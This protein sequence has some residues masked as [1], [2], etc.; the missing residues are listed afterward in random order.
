MPQCRY[1]PSGSPSRRRRFA[2]PVPR[3]KTTD[4]GVIHLGLDVS[5]DTIAVAILRPEELDAD[6]EKFVND[7]ASI[8]RLVDRFDDPRRLRA[9]FEAGPTGFE[10][11]RLLESLRVCTDVIAPSLIPRRPGDRVKTDKRDCRR[12]ARL[13]RAGELTAVRVPTRAEEGVRDLCRARHVAVTERRRARQRLSA[14]LLRHNEAWRE[15]SWTFRHQDWIAGRHFA[16]PATQAALIF[17]RAAVDAQDTIVGEISSELADWFDTEPFALPVHRLAAYRG[18]DHLGALSIVSEVCD[19]RRFAHAGA[20]MSFCGLV[21]QGYSSGQSSWRG[22]LTLAGNVHVRTQLVES[23]WAYSHAPRLGVEIA[24][25]QDGLP[26]ETIQRAWRAQLR[27]C[28]RFRRLST[29]KDS[30]NLV[31]AAI[32]RELAGFVYAELTA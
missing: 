21:P 32:A 23:A 7:E 5:K 16:D 19:F 30:R 29:R 11:H 10:L 28:G 24:R 13:H 27:L 14:F 4:R 15:H 31:I 3:T 18:I 9:C 8:R 20:F 25:R 6:A 12:L 1:M 17:Y 2:H 26:Q 22:H